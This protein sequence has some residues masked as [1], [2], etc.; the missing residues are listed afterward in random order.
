MPDIAVNPIAIY[1]NLTNAFRS[2][3]P[4]L[5]RF[6]LVAMS[7]LIPVSLFADSYAFT[8]IDVPGST[9]TLVTGINDAGQIVGTYTTGLGTATNA[10]VYSNGAY[11]TIQPPSNSSFYS[12]GGI[13]NSGQIVG[14]LQG[15]SG[16]FIDT[17]GVFSTIPSPGGRYT[18]L[19]PLG[20]NNSGQVT[21]ILN[22]NPAGVVGFLYSNGAVSTV[23]A[24]TAGLSYAFGIN[25]SGEIVGY[26]F[27][28]NPIDGTAQETAFVNVGGNATTLTVPGASG[29]QALGI[30][31]AGQIVGSYSISGVSGSNGFIDSNGVFIT[32]NAPGAANTSLVGINA[33]GDVVGNSANGAFLASPVPSSVPEPRETAVLGLLVLTAAVYARRWR[34]L[35]R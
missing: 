13:N 33:A 25:N 1:A 19:Q 6:S 15:N 10:F 2:E 4:A 7:L 26:T 32:L 35:S 3:Y 18:S 12:I 16:G 8:P 29:S 11:T 27:S 24:P 20:I 28:G 14:A 17:N 21:G 22:Y 34:R 23:N 30:N 9:S 31:D 5:K